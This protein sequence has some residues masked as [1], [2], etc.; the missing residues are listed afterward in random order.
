MLELSRYVVDNN[1][2]EPVFISAFE[3]LPVP[4]MPYVPN[5]TFTLADVNHEFLSA[6]LILSRIYE[7]PVPT[8]MLISND[9]AEKLQENFPLDKIASSANEEAAQQG[10]GLYRFA[11]GKRLEEPDFVLNEDGFLAPSLTPSVTLGNS[12]ELLGCE[13]PERLPDGHDYVLA[14][15]WKFVGEIEQGAYMGFIHLFDPNTLEIIAQDDHVLGQERYPLVVWQDDEI[16]KEVY[17]LAIGE[18]LPSG[19]YQLRL[20]VYSWPDQIRL[21]VPDNPDNIVELPY[22]AIDN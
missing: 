18:E 3:E 21:W 22:L 19:H 11:A 12:V 8:L 4:G 20:G 15:Y 17:S 2:G 5:T 1:A 7:N 16:I 9:D 6:E 13:A 10:Y 14:C